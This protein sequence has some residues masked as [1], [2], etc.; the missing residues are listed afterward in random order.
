MFI[1]YGMDIAG[2]QQS[3]TKT[4]S[5]P[6]ESARQQMNKGHAKHRCWAEGR[7]RDEK[8]GAK[9]GFLSESREGSPSS[10]FAM[11]VTVLLN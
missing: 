2:I 3:H 11:H 5:V 8:H 6:S 4:V 1:R 10:P 7:L 9:G